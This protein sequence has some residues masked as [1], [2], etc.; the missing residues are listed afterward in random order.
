VDIEALMDAN[1]YAK[2]YKAPAEYYQSAR[3]E[4]ARAAEIAAYHEQPRMSL[5][6]AAKAKHCG[7]CKAE[8]ETGGDVR[9]PFSHSFHN[10]EK[11]DAMVVDELQ[12]FEAGGDDGGGGGAGGG[13]S[14]GSAGRSNNES[15]GSSNSSSSQ[16][17]ATAVSSKSTSGSLPCPKPAQMYHTVKGRLIRRMS[18]GSLTPSER[19]RLAELVAMG[20]SSM[21]KK[22]SLFEWGDKSAASARDFEQE[23]VGATRACYTAVTTTNPDSFN[24]DGEGHGL[25]VQLQVAEHR[26]VKCMVAV[27]IY[28][29]PA[30]MLAETLSAIAR[31]IKHL[32]AHPVH[33]TDFYDENGHHERIWRDIV[34]TV[35]ADGRK[36]MPKDTVQWLED[37]VSGLQVNKAN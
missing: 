1:G 16:G 22:R 4:F 26:N 10:S 19:V 33:S 12:K 28:D 18:A 13:G 32:Q 14:D 31:N 17:R 34:T 36:R 2:G 9:T 23:D 3:Q 25:Q 35:V 8:L 21:G 6:L 7:V 24:G 5:F 37:M 30:T 11:F 15:D 20:Y 29:E 27:T